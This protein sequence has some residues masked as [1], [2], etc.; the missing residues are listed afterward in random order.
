MRKIRFEFG[1]IALEAELLQTPTA[2]AIWNKLP[3]RAEVLR[4]GEE[5]YFEVP[6]AIKARVRRAGGRGTRRDRLLA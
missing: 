1:S 4:W 6:V 2:N 3:I 5:V